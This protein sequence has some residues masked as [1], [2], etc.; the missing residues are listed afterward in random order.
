M[1]RQKMVFLSELLRSATLPAAPWA[2]SSSSNE[3]S[4]TS[5]SRLDR[6]ALHADSTLF[7]RPTT[8]GVF[9]AI[10]SPQEKLCLH[11]TLNSMSHLTAS[12]SQKFQLHESKAQSHVYAMLSLHSQHRLSLNAEM[13]VPGFGVFTLSGLECG[14]KAVGIPPNAK[15]GLKTDSII[16]HTSVDLQVDAVNGPSVEIGVVV[17]QNNVSF[18]LGGI[19]NTGMDYGKKKVEEWSMAARYIGPKWEMHASVREMGQLFRWNAVQCL[20]EESNTQ[21]GCEVEYQ[22]KKEIL[23]MK[24]QG[25]MNITKKETLYGTI[26]SDA[27]IGLAYRCMVTP[28]LKVGLCG[29]VDLRQVDTDAHQLGISIEIGP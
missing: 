15:V 13:D 22:H 2:T 29:Q 19:Y 8:S 25:Q 28:L 9:L 16:P 1:N 23:M 18:G 26:N 3:S 4:P 14:Q 5:R 24:A 6:Y 7:P 20:E 10:K 11:G 21:L 27:K 12:V 17:G